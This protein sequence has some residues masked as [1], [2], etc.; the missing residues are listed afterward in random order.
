MEMD[1]EMYPLFMA[2]LD[3]LVQH[4]ISLR[5]FWTLP[6]LP[7]WFSVLL[8]CLIFLETKTCVGDSAFNTFD[9]GAGIR[10]MTMAMHMYI[11]INIFL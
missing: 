1:R 7:N 10:C 6:Q 5:R 2:I 4:Q 9:M 8:R 11:Y 3:S